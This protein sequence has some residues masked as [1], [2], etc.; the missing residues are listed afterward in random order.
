VDQE[1]QVF[2]VVMDLDQEIL[3][4]LLLPLLTQVVVVVDIPTIIQ[5]I[6]VVLEDQV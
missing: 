3:E 1:L 2:Q 6:R 4:L 5:E